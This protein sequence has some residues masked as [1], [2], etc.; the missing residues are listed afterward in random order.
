[1]SEV[2]A[3]QT[4]DL[5]LDPQHLIKKLGVAMCLLNVRATRGGTEINPRG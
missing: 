2:F 5:N 1:M 3:A 4:K